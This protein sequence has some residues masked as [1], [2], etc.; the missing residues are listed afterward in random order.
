[1]AEAGLHGGARRRARVHA[2]YGLCGPTAR[3]GYGLP[4]LSQQEEQDH[5]VLTEGSDRPERQ[6][7]VVGSEV[8]A[9]GMGGAHGEVNAGRLWASDPHG[10]VCGAPAEVPRG[11]G[12]SESH[13]W[14]GI[15]AVDGFHLQRRRAQF[16]PH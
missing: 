6:R 15:K 5:G 1:M 12:R 2:D 10:S 9:A 14:R 7:R 16:R 11:L 3:V 13:L 4:D 8:R